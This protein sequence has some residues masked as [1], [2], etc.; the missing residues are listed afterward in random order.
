MFEKKNI[1]TKMNSVEDFLLQLQ[2]DNFNSIVS[3]FNIDNKLIYKFYKI[4]SDFKNNINN[5]LKDLS[6]KNVCKK[7]ILD[8]LIKIIDKYIGIFIDFINNNYENI[9]KILHIKLYFDNNL[10]D[11]KLKYKENLKDFLSIEREII[12][13]WKSILFHFFDLQKVYDDIEKYYECIF[14]YIDDI[15]YKLYC[16][17]NLNEILIYELKTYLKGINYL[18][19]MYNL[20]YN[21]KNISQI[22][23]ND[24]VDYIFNYVYIL[25]NRDDK[26][27]SDKSLYLEILN[28]D[29]L[30][31]LNINNLI[32]KNIKIIN[33]KF[34]IYIKN[35]EILIKNKRKEKEVKINN[36]S[37]I[38]QN[39]IID[40]IAIKFNS[41]EKIRFNIIK[42]FHFLTKFIYVLHFLR[43]LIILDLNIK[44]LILIFHILFLYIVK[45]Y[46]IVN[47]LI[48]IAIFFDIIILHFIGYIKCILL[49]D[50]LK[51][52]IF[53]TF[54]GCDM[55]NYYKWFY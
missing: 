11:F 38:N 54:D 6:E 53:L 2:D 37:Y 20:H 29:E 42:T 36:A 52:T 4:Y 19:K 47:Q 8:K 48:T 51:D 55:Y 24:I 18:L 17:Y 12:Q 30:T 43:A 45:K 7:K 3:D 35:K 1:I 13:R 31:S 9:I 34:R 23:P 16:K 25:K 15:N 22:F 28:L 44:L 41:D 49:Y 40:S 27:Y 32:N 46:H 21:K 39:H 10:I 33:K 5:Y 14:Q 50:Y 26:I